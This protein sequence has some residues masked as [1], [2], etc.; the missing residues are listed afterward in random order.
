MIYTEINTECLIRISVSHIV[1]IPEN[2][3]VKTF[4]VFAENGLNLYKS[5]RV[6]TVYDG[7]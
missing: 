4:L 6:S 3:K 5:L 2:T 1:I 7:I